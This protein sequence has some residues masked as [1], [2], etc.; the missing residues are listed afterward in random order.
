MTC[1]VVLI[2]NTREIFAHWAFPPFSD[3]WHVGYKGECEHVQRRGP[4]IAHGWIGGRIEE[5]SGTDIG[6][7]TVCFGPWGVMGRIDWAGFMDKKRNPEILNNLY[8][9]LVKIHKLRTDRFTPVHKSQPLSHNTY[10][11]SCRIK[12]TKHKN[13]AEQQMSFFHLTIKRSLF[14]TC[15]INHC[16]RPMLAHFLCGKTTTLKIT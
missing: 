8:N 16:P 3:V 9:T 11:N 12:T 10:I 2:Q 5:L 1:F 14:L 6:I 15:L 4:V 13:S 7:I